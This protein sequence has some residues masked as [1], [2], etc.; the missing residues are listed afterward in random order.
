MQEYLEYGVVI[1]LKDDQAQ[2]WEDMGMQPRE[3]FKDE[4]VTMFSFIAQEVIEYRQTYVKYKG[5]WR[6]CVVCVYKHDDT[7]FDTPAL[8]VSYE[9]F[10]KDLNDY[11]KNIKTGEEGIL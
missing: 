3:E 7:V 6:D 2:K 9:Q 11:K 5:E 4:R 10:K 1:E 8:L